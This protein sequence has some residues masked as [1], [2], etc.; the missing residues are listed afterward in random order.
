MIIRNGLKIRGNKFRAGSSPAARTRFLVRHMADKVASRRSHKPSER[1][2]GVPNIVHI[3]SS[4]YGRTI[5]FHGQIAV[6]RDCA[7]LARL[8]S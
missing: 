8:T 2:V 5:I 7:W 4:V 6:E 1:V 3:I